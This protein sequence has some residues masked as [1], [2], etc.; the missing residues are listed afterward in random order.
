MIK[1]DVISQHST[2]QTRAQAQDVRKKVNRKKNK[3]IIGNGEFQ[4]G[5]IT[6]TS[7]L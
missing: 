5:V 7:S 6:D 4:V 2:P 3:I 1:Y